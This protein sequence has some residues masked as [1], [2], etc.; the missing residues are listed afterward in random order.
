MAGCRARGVPLGPGSLIARPRGA[1]VSGPLLPATSLQGLASRTNR[2]VHESGLLRQGVCAATHSACR[3]PRTH[4]RPPTH[5]RTQA[6]IKEGASAAAAAA[7][8]KHCFSTGSS[9]SSLSLSSHSHS[10]R[11][12]SDFGCPFSSPCKL[13]VCVCA[14]ARAR[15]CDQIVG[16][17]RA[18][19]TLGLSGEKVDTVLLRI[20]S[21]WFRPLPSIY[22]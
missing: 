14:R 18:L 11:K 4:A 20:C 7:E 12:G 21:E 6:C 17:A 10:L 2:R 1:P 16:F 22:R 9:S 15:A 8:Q 3:R 19:E 5:A 13:C